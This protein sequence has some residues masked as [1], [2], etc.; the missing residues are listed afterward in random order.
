MKRRL[1]GKVFYLNRGSS[2]FGHIMV[3][4][5]TAL[6][7]GF[8][9]AVAWAQ[10]V[11]QNMQTPSAYI[12]YEIKGRRFRVPE[13]YIDIAPRPDQLNR[14][15][16]RQGQFGVAFWLSDG[17]PSPVRLIFSTTFWPKEPGRPTSGDTDFVV[18]AYHV[19]YLPPGEEKK[20]VLPSQRLQRVFANTLPASER[21]QETV[22]GLTC[23]TTTRTGEHSVFCATPSD[24]DLD[25]LFTTRWLESQWPGGRPPNPHWRA[26]IY[27][28]VDGLLISVS[29]PETALRRWADVVCRTLTLVRSWHTSRSIAWRMPRATHQLKFINRVSH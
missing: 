13:K 15:N 21:T 23:Y 26:E 14:V 1:R 5:S 29:F 17:N 7:G 24:T 19:E 16:V 6:V 28:K 2:V 12:D 22:H 25:V 11:E 8:D 18:N 20:E 10:A 9:A 27:S 4:L 3:A